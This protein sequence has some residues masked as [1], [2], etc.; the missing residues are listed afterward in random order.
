MYV[1]L[2]RGK[3]LRSLNPIIRL[4]PNQFVL[5]RSTPNLVSFTIS[6]LINVCDPRYVFF[7]RYA[8]CICP[9]KETNTKKHVAFQSNSRASNIAF[10]MELA[11]MSDLDFGLIEQNIAIKRLYSIIKGALFL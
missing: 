11:Q 9:K 8:K 7:R 1:Y 4:G 3:V 2:L 6:G 10:L 5:L